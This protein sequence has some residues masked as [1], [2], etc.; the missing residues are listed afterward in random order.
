MINWALAVQLPAAQTFTFA[1]LKHAHLHAKNLVWQHEKLSDNHN[2]PLPT[3]FCE[4]FGFAS[5]KFSLYLS[6]KMQVL[7]SV[8]FLF[9]RL[10]FFFFYNNHNSSAFSI[11]YFTF[12]EKKAH[13][14]FV[15]RATWESTQCRSSRRHL[16]NHLH[17]LF[18]LFSNT[19]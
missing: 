16:G 17:F 3:S 7:F 2:A 5:V 8:S 1:K 15:T 13:S 10:L 9:V 12:R 19:I 4:Q 18:N 6:L 11:K 14:L